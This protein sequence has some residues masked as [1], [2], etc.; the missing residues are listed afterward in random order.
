MKCYIST[1]SFG[2]SL[3]FKSVVLSKDVPNGIFRLNPDLALSRL[4]SFVWLSTCLMCQTHEII[5]P[6]CFLSLA[7]Y[8]HELI[9]KQESLSIDLFGLFGHGY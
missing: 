7:I 8:E 4:M 9:C 2:N 3:S 5:T 1:I 6:H